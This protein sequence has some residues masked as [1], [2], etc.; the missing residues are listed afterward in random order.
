MDPVI[1][2]SSF[3]EYVRST[4]TNPSHMVKNGIAG[5][6][7]VKKI[8]LKLNGRMKGTAAITTSGVN[9]MAMKFVNDRSVAS[10]IPMAAWL[11]AAF[12]KIC[13]A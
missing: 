7:Y 8:L 12:S 10:K 5:I 13:F 2:S 9:S 11:F 6:T 1:F 3:T 4:E